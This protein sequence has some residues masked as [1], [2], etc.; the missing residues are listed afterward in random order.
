MTRSLKFAG[1]LLFL[2]CV[3]CAHGFAAVQAPIS[4]SLVIQDSCLI[5]SANGGSPGGGPR[6]SCKLGAPYALKLAPRD[7]TQRRPVARTLAGRDQD[8]TVWTIAF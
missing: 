6:V 1:I 2:L 4:V 7:P 3:P 5:L 8:G